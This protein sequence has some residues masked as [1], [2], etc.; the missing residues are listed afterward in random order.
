MSVVIKAAVPDLNQVILHNPLF[1]PYQSERDQVVLNVAASVAKSGDVL[2]DDVRIM[3]D[4]SMSVYQ[5]SGYGFYYQV[6][7]ELSENRLLVTAANQR[8]VILVLILL[9]LQQRFRIKQ[10]V[11]VRRTGEFQCRGSRPHS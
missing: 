1:G 7:E 10:P 9:A 4:E 3:L 8:I 5:N 6:L 2:A 11:T